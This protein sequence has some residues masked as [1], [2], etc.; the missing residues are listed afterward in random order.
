MKYI[1]GYGT[2]KEQNKLLIITL[3][4]GLALALMVGMFSFASAA[5]P[6]AKPDKPTTI[7]SGVLEDS[8]GDVIEVGFD[9][10]G[11]NYQAHMFN[12]YYCDSYRDAPSCQPYKDVKL[13]MKWNDAWIANTDADEDGFLDRHYDHASYRGSGAWLTNHQSGEYVND[14]GETVKWNYFNKIVAAPTDAS[15]K[16]GIWYDADG[17]KIG[18]V[19]WGDFAIIQEVSN[20]AGADQHGVQYVSPLRAGL[21]NW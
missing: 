10:W 17:T 11:Y 15:L 8:E 1:Q 12:G 6:E 7:Q 18:P 5:K 16:G 2:V 3:A 9:D 4:V 14:N 13:T 19:I 21:G 20:D